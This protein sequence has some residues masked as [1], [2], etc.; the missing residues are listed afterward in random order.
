MGG[1]GLK[2]LILIVLGLIFTIGIGFAQSLPTELKYAPSNKEFKYSTD[3]KIELAV[4][5]PKEFLDRNLSLKA[6]IDLRYDSLEVIKN[7]DQEQMIIDLSISKISFKSQFLGKKYKQVINSNERSAIQ[8]I[9][10]PSGE[11]LDVIL[12][13]A[14]VEEVVEINQ[15]EELKSD[16]QDSAEE[17]NQETSVTDDEG[18]TEAEIELAKARLEEFQ[19]NFEQTL[20]DFLK[21]YFGLKYHILPE[22]SVKIGDSWTNNHLLKTKLKLLDDGEGIVFPISHQLVRFKKSGKNNLAYFKTTAD[23]LFEKTIDL[24]EL[25]AQMLS[26]EKNAVNSMAESGAEPEYQAEDGDESDT[27]SYEFF[28]F[29]SKID[30]KLPFILNGET[31]FDLTNGCL[32][33]RNIEIKGVGQV[34][35][36]KFDLPIQTEISYKIKVKTKRK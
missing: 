25:K 19:K 29:G 32:Y 24:Q 16:S 2:K 6:D 35:A 5:P 8:L 1:T 13:K 23:V 22:K 31:V 11:V 9:L 7:N 20:V 4:K 33:S 18:M 34:T 14:D 26:Q 17:G 3:I 36:S 10:A 28:G 27:D 12:K 30:Y 15:L 21:F